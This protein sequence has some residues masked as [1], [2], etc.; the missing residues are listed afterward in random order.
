LNTSVSREE[1]FTNEEYTPYLG[2]EISG[3]LKPKDRNF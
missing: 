2:P 3:T 1:L